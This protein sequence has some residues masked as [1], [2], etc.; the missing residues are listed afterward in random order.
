M[1]EDTYSRRP[2]TPLGTL[3]LRHTNMYATIRSRSA[4]RENRNERYAKAEYLS[5]YIPELDPQHER[6]KTTRVKRAKRSAMLMTQMGVAI[7]VVLIVSSFLL[8]AVLSYPPDMRGVG[9]F[10]TGNCSSTSSANT[11]VHVILNIASSLFLGA[12]N[13]CMQILIAPSREEMDIA[14]RKGKT[15]EVGVPSIKNLR[16]ISRKRTVAWLSIGLL[17]TTLHVL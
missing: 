3:P 14:H 17:G 15:V 7:A 6:A 13:Y 8:W 1:K 10:Y 2:P 4:N 5:K 16:H 11:A 9:T 12:G